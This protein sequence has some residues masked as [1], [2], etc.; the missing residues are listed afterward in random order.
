MFLLPLQLHEKNS[1]LCLSENMNSVAFSNSHIHQSPLSTVQSV[2]CLI[3]PIG[4]TFSNRFSCSLKALES[5]IDFL[6]G[7]HNKNLTPGQ[8]NGS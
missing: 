6:Q 1:V 8:L 2:L 3:L 5:E 4:S 7:I